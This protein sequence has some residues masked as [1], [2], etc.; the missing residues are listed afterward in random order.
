MLSESVLKKAKFPAC[1]PG[2]NCPELPSLPVQPGMAPE[3]KEQLKPQPPIGRPVT[4]GRSSN[5]KSAME[6]V[7][8]PAVKA[9]KKPRVAIDTILEVVAVKVILD[10]SRLRFTRNS[11][12]GAS[13]CRI[14]VISPKNFT[15]E[16][17]RLYCWVPA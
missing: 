17:C 1:V 9:L 13:I 6:I 2:W 16:L 12:A 5:E 11:A 14:S 15:I 7:D 4:G 8:A 10:P 3:L